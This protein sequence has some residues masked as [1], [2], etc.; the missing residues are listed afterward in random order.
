[1]RPRTGPLICR[2]FPEL[3]APPVARSLL[4]TPTATPSAG[5]VRRLLEVCAHTVPN[6]GAVGRTRLSP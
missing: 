2:C 4:P 5:Q 3:A 1:M 6:R